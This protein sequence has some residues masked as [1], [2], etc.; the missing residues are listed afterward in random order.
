MILV[1]LFQA[2]EYDERNILLHAK[3]EVHSNTVGET[4]T[5]NM[6]RNPTAA[7]NL[8]SVGKQYLALSKA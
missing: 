2:R 3:D 1:R 8:F 7:V 6:S 4:S 5:I